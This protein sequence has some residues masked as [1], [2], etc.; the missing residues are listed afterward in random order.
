MGIVYLHIIA[1]MN[2]LIWKC[3]VVALASIVQS[4]GL[5]L[6]RLS[7][8][9]RQ[10]PRSN[11]VLAPGTSGDQAEQIGADFSRSVRLW[12]A[13]IALFIAANLFGST[14]QLTVL[15]LVLVCTL[16]ATGIVANSLFATIVLNEPL[17]RR[18]VLGT[19]LVTVGAVC[20]AGLGGAKGEPNVSLRDLLYMYVRTPFLLWM[21]LTIVIAIVLIYISRRKRENLV[22]RGC[23]WGIVGGISSAHSLLM[24]KLAVGQVMRDLAHALK[25]FSH[26]QYWVILLLFLFFAVFQMW[27]VNC[28]LQFASTAVLYP[29]VFCVYNLVTLGNSLMLYGFGAVFDSHSIGWVAAGTLVLLSGVLLL[30]SRF[31]DVGDLESSSHHSSSNLH[32]QLNTPRSNTPL[33]PYLRTSSPLS[34]HGSGFPS[35]GAVN[36]GAGGGNG[37]GAGLGAGTAIVAGAGPG[38][39]PS[40]GTSPGSG[41]G[42][43]GSSNGGYRN[44]SG[45]SAHS[46]SSANLNGGRTTNHN[47]STGY[48]SFDSLNPGIANPDKQRGRHTKL[49][50]SKEQQKILRELGI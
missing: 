45:M 32:L 29:L 49:P 37:N 36:S 41:T 19:V 4:F 22:L 46:A 39:G 7:H 28:G 5:T 8:I 23:L 50:L 10:I 12:R 13:G 18:H 17:T 43:G 16:Q 35:L 42:L 15:P 25:L 2:G 26:V 30:S 6:Q 20:V 1:C 31:G 27:S 44:F 34:P 21:W 9:D 24:A 38:S 3:S 11:S 48:T 47:S 40:P 33:S 14:V